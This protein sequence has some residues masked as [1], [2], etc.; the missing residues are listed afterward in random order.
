M[1]KPL[2]LATA[3]LLLFGG[4]ACSKDTAQDV[5]DEAA[6]NAEKAAEAV[7]TEGKKAA[8]RAEDMVNDR[9]VEIEDFKFKPA[10]KTVKVGTEITWLNH[11]EVQ[12]TATADNDSF[13]SKQIDQNKEFSY[14]FTQ[15]G[16]YKYHCENHPNQMEGTITVED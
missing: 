12:H 3:V 15:E 1:R 14:R 8:D 11:G 5:A 9:N 7:A 13:D 6:A 16:K 10:S 2:V 4:L